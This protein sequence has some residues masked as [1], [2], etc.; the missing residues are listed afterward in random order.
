M[1]DPAPK[2]QRTAHKDLN[3][4]CDSSHPDIKGKEK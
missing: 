2:P 1:Q 4:H 3:I